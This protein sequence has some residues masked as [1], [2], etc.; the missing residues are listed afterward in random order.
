M[1][2]IS[3]GKFWRKKCLHQ[4]GPVQFHLSLQ[5][6]YGV[7]LWEIFTKGGQPYQG[8]ENLD[9]REFLEKG[10]RSLAPDFM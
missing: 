10:G 5:W 1:P 7:L 2:R 6:S 9:I 4:L 8:L 3:S